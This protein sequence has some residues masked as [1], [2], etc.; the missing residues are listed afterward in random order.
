[1][2]LKDSIIFELKQLKKNL[3]DPDAKERIQKIRVDLNTLKR[4]KQS[5]EVINLIEDTLNT[6]EESLDSKNKSSGGYQKDDMSQQLLH[7]QQVNMKQQDEYLDEILNIT[8]SLKERANNIGQEVDEHNRL[9]DDVDT[10][11]EKQ[12][13]ALDSAN[14]RLKR[15]LI[16]AK[17]NTKFIILGVLA[18]II[19]ILIIVLVLII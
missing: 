7:H 14:R 12:L 17:K 4:Q 3:N 19:V 16:D 11:V 6:L 8:K 15:V 13:S 5:T 1:M 10:D 9:L 2:S 18:V